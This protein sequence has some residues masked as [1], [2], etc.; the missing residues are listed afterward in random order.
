MD[1]IIDTPEQEIRVFRYAGFWI[2]VGAYL[3]DAVILWVANFI[4]G[5][6]GIGSIAFD[7]YNYAFNIISLT[8]GVLYFGFME[9]S[10]RQGTLGKM[11]VGIKVGDEQGNRITFA[12]ALGRYFAKFISAILLGIGFLMVAWDERKQGIHDKLADTYVFED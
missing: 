11:A 6:I 8:M 4:I 2:R 7:E 9:S 10:E 5:L 3:I 1:Q 12:N